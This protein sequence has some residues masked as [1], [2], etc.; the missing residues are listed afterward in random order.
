MACISALRVCLAVSDSH[1]EVCPFF[2][3]GRHAN[4]LLE[5]IRQYY[6]KER[7]SLLRLLKLCLCQWHSSWSLTSDVLF[8]MTSYNSRKDLIIESLAR[9]SCVIGTEEYD[10][11]NIVEQRLKELVELLELILLGIHGIRFS[12]TSE[13][14]SVLFKKVLETFWVSLCHT[15]KHTL[16][17]F[18]CIF[19]LESQ[20][21]SNAGGTKP[22]SCN[23]PNQSPDST[24]K[25]FDHKELRTTNDMFSIS[26]HCAQVAIKKLDVFHFL[27][28]KLDQIA[29]Q[30]PQVFPMDSRVSVPYD[31]RNH[32]LVS[33]GACSAIFDLITLLAQGLKIG[34]DMNTAVDSGPRIGYRIFGLIESL[35]ESK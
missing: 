6:W 16:V 10:Q 32:S 15:N 24:N 4:R 21:T 34:G 1:D 11:F 27:T 3:T 7:L 33:L 31:D 9:G 13:N 20:D 14:P 17:C 5:D 28:G 35:M 22:D 2:I 25:L 23:K 19:L 30:P 12:A 26:N 18:F 8:A 29:C